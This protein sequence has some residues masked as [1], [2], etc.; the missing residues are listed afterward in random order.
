MFLFTIASVTLLIKIRALQNS[1]NNF[2]ILLILY[3][4]FL[5]CLHDYIQIRVSLAIAICAWAI[6]VSKAL[7]GV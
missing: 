2:L 5:L 3:S 4:S 7:S 1:T 6:Y